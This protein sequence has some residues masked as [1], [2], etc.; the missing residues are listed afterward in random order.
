MKRT[1]IIC[2][3]GP[4]SNN[5][6][7][8]R[9]LILNG[10]NIAR[11]NFS[12]GTHESHAELLKLVREVSE[13]LD[14]PVA[15]LLDTK[16]PEIRTGLFDGEERYVELVA[17][18]KLILTINDIKG[19]K[20]KVSITYPGLVDDV[21]IGDRILV[22]DG[23]IELIVESK[24]SENIYTRIVNGGL[25][26]ERKGIN[27]PGTHLEF[28]VITEK[29]KE[30]IIF[31]I[32]QD[33]DFIAASFVR[34]KE[35]ILAIKDILNEYGA[36]IP[37]ISKIECLE[38]IEN[39]EDIL[40]YSDGIMIARGDLGVEIPAAQV[41]FMQK[42]LIRECNKRYKPVIVATQM[43]D[44][45]M[46]NPRPTRAEVN[47]VANAIYEGTDCV[48]LSGESAS[49]KYPVEALQT[50]VSICKITEGHIDF[51]KY[52]DKQKMH[53]KFNYS[54]AVSASTVSIA[55]NIGAKL[56]VTPT[57][58]GQTAR[59]VSRFRP[60]CIHIGCSPNKRTVRKMQI[61][62]GVIPFW[63]EFSENSNQIIQGA[64]D[65]C[66]N[67]GY[68]QKGDL[69]VVT[70]GMQSI[71]KGTKQDANFTN[72]IRVFVAD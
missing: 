24:D 27:T 50:M 57:M 55:E 36:N 53:R 2:T 17:G 39:L 41:P 51:M 14:M 37:V 49:G 10:M 70:S 66:R 63:Q 18:E 7:V 4:A 44:S 47:D 12:H 38:A 68:I 69:F 33:F 20:E 43:L 21:K 56:V 32:E 65:I 48:M 29:D 13:E 60:A 71:Y 62:W 15:T 35:S 1:K 11:F 61:Y 72:T 19:S 28:P 22:D 64:I 6:E 40:H 34:S 59:F 5:K 52:T 42:K 54:S 25:L 45:M 46:R 16:G 8:L 26:G 23:L 67:K 3:L 9:E 31:G 58:S 30:D